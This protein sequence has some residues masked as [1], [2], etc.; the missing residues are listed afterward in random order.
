MPQS[1]KKC[2]GSSQKL[3]NLQIFFVCFLLSVNKIFFMFDANFAKR[4]VKKKSNK[5]DHGFS[6][7]HC[8]FFLPVRIS[9]LRVLVVLVVVGGQS[10]TSLNPP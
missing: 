5:P 2:I 10:L 7:S 1:S 6:L 9:V 8:F 3:A 4:N